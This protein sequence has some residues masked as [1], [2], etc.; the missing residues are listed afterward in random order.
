MK[1]ARKPSK[2]RSKCTNNKKS[3]LKRSTMAKK[4]LFNVRNSNRIRRK[5]QSERCCEKS[6]ILNVTS[7]NAF[8]EKNNPQIKYYFLHG[9]N[10]SQYKDT[11]RHH[12][13]S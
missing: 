9:Y 2:K 13:K 1:A 5:R 8:K 3:T 4:Q 11:R 12:K 7:S 6:K 10:V